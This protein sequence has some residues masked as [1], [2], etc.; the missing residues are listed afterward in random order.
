LFNWLFWLF[1]FSVLWWRHEPHIPLS[2]GFPGWFPAWAAR[3]AVLAALVTAAAWTAAALLR[4]PWSRWV[5]TEQELVLANKHPPDTFPIQLCGMGMIMSLLAVLGGALLMK[6]ESKASEWLANP[7][8]WMT[9]IIIIPIGF[10][11]AWIAFER[12]RP[13]PPSGTPLSHSEKR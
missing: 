10:L 7:D 3:T 5:R 11:L 12:R 13:R 9:M 8:K 2:L 4:W 1:A 6:Y